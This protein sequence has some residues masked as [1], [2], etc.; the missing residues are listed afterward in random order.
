MQATV[1]FGLTLIFAALSG[2]VMA[3]SSAAHAPTSKKPNAHFA[4][5]DANKD[6]FLSYAEARADKEA[7]QH[8]ALYDENRD[9]KLSE[10]EFLK[11]KAAQ[12]DRQADAMRKRN[13]CARASFMR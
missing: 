10:D 6:G 11:L 7:A 3:Q 2:S 9:G 1:R 13:R 12:A 5:L 8:F 4:R